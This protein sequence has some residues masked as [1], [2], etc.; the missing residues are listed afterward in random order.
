MLFSQASLFK[1]LMIKISSISSMYLGDTNVLFLRQLNIWVYILL[2]GEV[3][4]DV[5]PMKRVFYAACNSIFANAN[6]LDEIALLSLQ[7]AYSPSV[8][9]YA[10][11][12]L[13]LSAKQTTELNVCLNMVFHRIFCCNKWELVRAITNGSVRLDVKLLILLHEVKFVP[14]C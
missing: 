3:C 13:H 8:L 11:P 5:N 7:E 10:A 9:M 1:N 2:Q 6:G 4:F 12:A 14:C